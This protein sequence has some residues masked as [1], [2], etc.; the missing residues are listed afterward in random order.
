MKRM[1]AVF[2]A[3]GAVACTTVTDVI[4]TGQDTYAVTSH[5]QMGWT[6][7]PD[8]RAKALQRA[9]EYCSGL[10]KQL[11]TIGTTDSGASGFGTVSS[12]QVQFR[13]VTPAA[14]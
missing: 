6:S 1:T 7:G 9:L 12:A 4:P 2:A 10:G 11:E 3:V 13:C 14:H 8:Q 5:D